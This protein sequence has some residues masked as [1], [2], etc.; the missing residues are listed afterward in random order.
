MP[1]VPVGLDGRRLLRGDS[2]LAFNLLGLAQASS[3]LRP[4]Q[5]FARLQQTSVPGAS[6]ARSPSTSP[7]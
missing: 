1:V 5:L 7:W 3:A 4:E 6:T 2:A